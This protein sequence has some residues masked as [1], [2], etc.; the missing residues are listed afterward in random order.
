M[1]TSHLRF[2]GLVRLRLD[3]EAVEQDVPNLLTPGR[4]CELLLRNGAS[5]RLTNKHGKLAAE[6][7]TSH[8]HD[9]C[10]RVLRAAEADEL[11]EYTVS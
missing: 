6:L 8:N 7:A 4:V 1:K 2:E 10:A 9:R 11:R 3:A 5:A